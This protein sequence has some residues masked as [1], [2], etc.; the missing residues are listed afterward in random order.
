MKKDVSY[1]PLKS[2]KYN[3]CIFIFRPKLYLLIFLLSIFSELLSQG[4][5]T[6]QSSVLISAGVARESGLAVDG[7]LSP[8]FNENSCTLTGTRP[9]FL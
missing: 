8:M 2:V 9:K 3:K 5:P 4:K 7:N 1:T 6:S